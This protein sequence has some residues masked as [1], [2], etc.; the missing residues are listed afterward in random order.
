MIWNRFCTRYKAQ[1]W[2]VRGL[3]DHVPHLAADLCDP[4]RTE[5]YRVDGIAPCRNG[6][7]DHHRCH[8]CFPGTETSPNR[9]SRVLL[10]SARFGKH[11]QWILFNFFLLIFEKIHWPPTIFNYLAFPE[12]PTKIS[13]YFIV[14]SSFPLHFLFRLQSQTQKSR[15]KSS[16]KFSKL[17]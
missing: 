4:C 8:W 13:V 11:S 15:R 3:D 16:R 7:H 10:F 17:H 9:G 12:I 5:G 2:H 1:C 6:T 14:S